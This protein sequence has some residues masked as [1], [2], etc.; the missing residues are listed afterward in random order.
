MILETL[1]SDLNLN[2]TKQLNE[3]LNEA[4]E[5]KDLEEWAKT[6]GGKLSTS[7]PTF[8]LNEHLHKIFPIY[9]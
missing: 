1:G 4:L 6:A 9:S 7:T 2:S 8:K 3:W 5:Q